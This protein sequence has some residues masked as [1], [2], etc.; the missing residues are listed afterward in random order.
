MLIMQHRHCGKFMIKKKRCR[1]AYGGKSMSRTAR[2]ALALLLASASLSPA[3]ATTFVFAG[4]A[5]GTQEFPPN[6]SPGTGNVTVTWDDVAHTMAVEA[7]FS[8]LIGTTTASHIHVS[9]PGEPAGGVATQTPSF[10][11]FPLGVTNGT[12]NNTFD[13]TLASS[14]RA[15]FITDNG[16][17]VA[18]A[19]AALLTALLDGR[20]YFNIHTTEFPGGEI[21]AN[22]ALV[23]EPGTWMLMLGGFAAV[24]L[25]F[26][27]R[28]AREAVPV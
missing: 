14:Y 21:R 11:G 16:G 20:A 22:L 3:A 8:G 28:R 25:A 17:T 2:V 23:P 24:G 4:T 10:I 19:E 6:A 18:G 13:M 12:F 7:F 26:R 9:L 27:R 1:G 15:G 5:T